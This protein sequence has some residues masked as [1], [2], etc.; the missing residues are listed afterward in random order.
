MRPIW[1]GHIS[2]GL[3]SVPVTLYPAEQR[4]ELGFHMIDSRNNA[5]VR[6]QRVNAE[7]GEEVPWDEIVKGYEYE[8]GSYVIMGKDELQRLAPEIT[9]TVDI[10]AFVDLSAIDI[11][12]FD[13]PYYLEPAK[14]GEK[15]YALLR[16][17]LEE[18]G[19]AGIARVVLRTRQYIAAMVARDGALVLNLLRY[20]D[21]LRS[22]EDLKLPREAD[23]LGTSKQELKM[24]RM[25]VDSM[26]TE[27]DPTAYRDVYR[28]EVVRWIEKRVEAGQILRAPELAEVEEEAPR[29][30]N[31]ME[32]LKKSLGQTQKTTTKKASKSAGK[33]QTKKK[34]G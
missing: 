13:K 9:R 25:L 1:K 10:E 30:I 21:E 4:N 28:E 26:T 31:L 7:T 14:N 11:I 6:Y 27:W 5:R 3:V 24:A 15:G 33:K 12:Y 20:H 22:T 34:A 2:F 19:K 8:N 29:P 17:T 16:Q 23:A 32:A 18:T